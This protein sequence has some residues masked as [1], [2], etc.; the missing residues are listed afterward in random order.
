[1]YIVFRDIYYNLNLESIM[2]QKNILIYN[3][4]LS[5][6]RFLRRNLFLSY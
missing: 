3:Y 2:K 1:M 6:V 4:F 5:L